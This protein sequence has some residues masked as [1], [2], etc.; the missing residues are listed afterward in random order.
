MFIPHTS[1]DVLSSAGDAGGKREREKVTT[2]SYP[3][4]NQGGGWGAGNM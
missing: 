2:V 1:V 3:W 4:P